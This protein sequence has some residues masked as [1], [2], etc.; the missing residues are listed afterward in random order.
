MEFNQID[1]TINHDYNTANMSSN[2]LSRYARQIILPE[3]GEEGQKILGD[4]SI[5]VI[6]CGAL[7]NII[8]SCLARGG[9]GKI[10]LVD[11]DI[12][13]LNN[14]H[15]QMLFDEGDVG[16]PK[17]SQAKKKLEIINSDIELV[18]LIED[19]NANNIE[20]IIGGSDIVLDGTDN[21]ETR[22]LINDACVKNEIPWIY[23]GAV[24]TVGM[25][26]NILPKKTCCLVCVFPT[27]PLIATLPT[28][29][30]AG[31]LNTVPIVIGA[32]QST[33]AIKILLGKDINMDL[34]IYD[35]WTHEFQRIKVH[36]NSQCPCC[37]QNDFKYLN[38]EQKD[39]TTVLCGRDAVQ[40]KPRM[41]MST[42]LE[43][44]ADIL[45]AVGEVKLLPTHI[46]FKHDNYEFTIFKDGRTIIKG[47]DDIGIAKSLYAKYIGT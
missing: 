33:E 3:I 29:E 27:P 46:T 1:K 19:V 44:L 14:I 18:S 30:T 45:K 23:G 38:A 6:G 7:G 28:C 31:I 8:A 34:I 4:H 11:R 20:D 26:M 15:R 36:R 13:D 22:Y 43:N 47:T 5:T 10:I 17:A 37:V 2:N 42:S 24:S 39:V 12:V 40:V 21:M 41:D 25:S 16:K 35:I 9:I 32:I